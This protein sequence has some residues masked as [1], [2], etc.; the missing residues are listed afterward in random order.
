[1]NYTE[2]QEIIKNRIQNI[3]QN[4]KVELKEV[5]KWN[6][7]IDDDHFGQ[8]NT[9]VTNN[10]RDTWGI[11][12]E[13]MKGIAYTNVKVQDCYAI[14]NMIDVLKDVHSNL[15]EENW[16]E[17]I[18]ESKKWLES[19]QTDLHP[20]YVLTNRDKLYGAAGILEAEL[21]QKIGYR[22]KADYYILPSSVHEI[23]LLPK[24]HNTKPEE[25]LEMVQSINREVVNSQEFLSDNI[26]LYEWQTGTLSIIE[27]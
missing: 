1:M 17:C 11:D 15:E 19:E 25:L 2:F 12:I 20:I 7:D 26:Y 14:K 3:Y 27:G 4:F 22:F 8:A 16:E 6:I 21:L 24:S 10:L 5:P 18:A 23:I 13:S 9:V